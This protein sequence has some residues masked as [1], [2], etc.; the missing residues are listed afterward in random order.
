MTRMTLKN[1][2][3]Y[4]RSNNSIVSNLDLSQSLL[5]RDEL[6]ELEQALGHP[7][8]RTLLSLDMR[9]CSM[10]DEGAAALFRGLAKNHSA[11]R[12]DL[13]NSTLGP[14]GVRALADALA[15]NSTL[16]TLSVWGCGLGPA[17]AETL[18]AGLAENE[19]LKEVVIFLFLPPCC[20]DS[21][22]ADSMYTSL[23][24]PV[25]CDLHNMQIR[26][27]VCVCVC[28]SVCLVCLSVCLAVSWTWA[29]T[30]MELPACITWRKLWH[31]T[32]NSALSTVM[33]TVF[34]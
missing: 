4:I 27:C 20:A 3:P 18:F 30:T 24:R 2:L 23:Q 10:S 1:A 9:G 22:R 7:F 29:T 16:A 15:S 6:Q 13:S 26:V 11:T 19:S 17:R 33:T 32:L 8:C 31:A 28:V 14:F 34:V 25:I 21:L 5:E 12:L